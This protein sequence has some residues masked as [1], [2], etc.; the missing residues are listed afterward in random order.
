MTDQQAAPRSSSLAFLSN[1]KFCFPNFHAIS[2][3]KNQKKREN[4][5]EK[6]ES[7]IPFF[8]RKFHSYK[9]IS[10]MHNDS[11]CDPITK[12]ILISFIKIERNVIEVPN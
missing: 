11:F 9:Q 2:L 7:K 3:F 8:Q 4:R 6:T 5:K 1:S 10:Y 12:S